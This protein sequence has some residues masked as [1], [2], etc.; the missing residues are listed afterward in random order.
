MEELVVGSCPSSGEKVNGRAK[1]VP[2]SFQNV[3]FAPFAAGKRLSKVKLVVQ[4]P[5]E[6]T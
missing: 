4:P 6:A 3:R 1:G 5:P 2:S